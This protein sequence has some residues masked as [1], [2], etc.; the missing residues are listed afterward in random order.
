MN[1]EHVQITIKAIKGRDGR[2]Y[3]DCGGQMMPVNERHIKLIDHDC[4]Q[5]HVAMRRFQNELD[6]PN[7]AE[8][9]EVL[10]NGGWHY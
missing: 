6:D 5:G 8:Y 10:D 2:Y 7:R 9:E 4:E 3:V 1:I